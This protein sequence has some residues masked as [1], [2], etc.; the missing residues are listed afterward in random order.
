ML[1]C[2]LVIMFL[3]SA[4]KK[5]GAIIP[6]TGILKDLTGLDGCRWVIELDKKN[7]GKVLEPVNLDDF[8]VTLENGQ[9]VKLSYVTLGSP[10]IC[11]V[12]DVV[13][14]KSLRDE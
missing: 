12:G 8:N 10:S 5:E 4:C 3:L 14:L 1:I 13:E 11:M 9:K 6:R 7:D 2:M